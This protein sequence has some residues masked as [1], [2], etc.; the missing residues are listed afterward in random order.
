MLSVG[1][2]NSWTV[3]GGERSETLTSLNFYFQKIIVFIEER[4]EGEKTVL[5]KG[6]VNKMK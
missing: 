6:L 2:V 3:S 4:I 5:A 1:R